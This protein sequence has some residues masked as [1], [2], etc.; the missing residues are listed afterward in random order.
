MHA[1]AKTLER[2]D[3]LKSIFDQTITYIFWS[4]PVLE[5]A[6]EQACNCRYKVTDATLQFK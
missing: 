3:N 5:F 1:S 4:Y 2:Y 6:T